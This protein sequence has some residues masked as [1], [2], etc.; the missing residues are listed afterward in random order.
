[1][2][3]TS[4]L[5]ESALDD[6]EYQASE[7]IRAKSYIVSW[8]IAQG[9]ADYSALTV[10]ERAATLPWAYDVIWLE[11]FRDR[12]TARLPE[13][14]LEVIKGIRL[15][16]LRRL[17]TL[18]DFGGFQPWVWLTIDQTGVGPFALDPFSERGM[19]PIGIT[20]HGGDAVTRS[21]ETGAYRVPKR[22][23]AS[24]VYNLLESGRLRVAPQL[25]DA[26]ILR[27]ELGN[28]RIKITA[29]GHDRYEAGDGVVWREGEHDDMV[30]SVACGV[31][32]GEQV[33]VPS[34]LDPAMLAAFVGLP[35]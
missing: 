6:V 14:T 1:M 33:L 19:D 5:R 20:I 29:T 4:V 27:A 13:R 23:L 16:D 30:L 34:G 31:W 24:A 7:N 12:R 18:G 35:G 26:A 11:R 10:L 21:A 8:D 22:D 3:A 9:G 15:R 17:Q 2:G 32:L 25:P 28:F